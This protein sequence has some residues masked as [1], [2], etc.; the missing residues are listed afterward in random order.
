MTLTA[1]S[2]NVR[3]GSITAGNPT[4]SFYHNFTI[5][6]NGNKADTNTTIDRNL[7][8]NK[9]F[10]VTGSL[11]LYG[12]SPTTVSTV[13]TKTANI[14]DTSINVAASID[15]RVGDTLVLS[16]SFSNATEYETVYIASILPN[17]T[18]TLNTSLLY[19]HY[20]APN[21]TIDNQFG[22]LDTRTRVGHVSRNIKIVPGPDADNWGFTTIVYGFVNQT[23]RV[24]NVILDGVQF[25]NG[26]QS[27]TRNPVLKFLNTWNGNLTSSV[28]ASSFL[29]CKASCILI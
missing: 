9:F 28:T 1:N 24:G 15:W 18:V 3:L 20:G 5:Q 22:T 14:G 16:P 12:I 4:T 19:T 26:S 8:A 27:D 13:L 23:L 7:Q 6:I 25:V 2:I 21:V 10:V 17:G 11:N 29:N